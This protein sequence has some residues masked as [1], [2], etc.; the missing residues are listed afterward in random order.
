MKKFFH[1]LLSPIK[2]CRKE[3]KVG[4]FALTNHAFESI[5]IYMERIYLDNAAT[6]PLD[7]EVLEKMLPYLTEIYGNAD[8]PHALGR[9]SAGAVDS[10]RDALAESLGAKPSEIYFTS[11]GTEAD[12][13]AILG[14][15]RAQ[16]NGEKRIS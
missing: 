13:W 15:A 16:K 11:G 10:A 8:S 3:R 1:L 9:F 4:Y 5:I 14:G 6:T 7:R 2:N 12:N